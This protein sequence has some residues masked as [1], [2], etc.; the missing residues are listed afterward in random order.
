MHKTECVL[1]IETTFYRILTYNE[2]PN[3][4]DQTECYLTSR[5]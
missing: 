5:K 3:L 1:K 2:L 4:K